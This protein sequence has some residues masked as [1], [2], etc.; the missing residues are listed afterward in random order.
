MTGCPLE[1]AGVDVLHALEIA[2]LM[3]H[4]LPPLAGG[5]LDQTRVF[6]DA[7]RFIWSERARMRAELGIGD[8]G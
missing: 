1:Y 6:L 8:D 2:E 7:A 3:K 4:G 5:S